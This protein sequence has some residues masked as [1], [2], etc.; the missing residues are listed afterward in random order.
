MVTLLLIACLDGPGEPVVLPEADYDAF[1]ADV[2]PVLEVGCANPSCHGSEARPFR[3]FAARRH[4]LD[5]DELYRATPLTDEELT[6]DY[7]C[8]A[9]F[10]VDLQNADDCQLLTKPLDPEDGGSEHRGGVQFADVEEPG[11]QTIAA[12]VDDALARSAP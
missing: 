12:W 7:E 11:Y 10:L 4:R 1:V 6:L 2:H 3:V 5:P 9:S 8:A